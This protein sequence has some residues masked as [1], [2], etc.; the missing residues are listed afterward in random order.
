MRKNIT[1]KRVIMSLLL[2]GITTSAAAAD[3][4][5]IEKGK[6]LYLSNKKGNCIACH[7]INDPDATLPG[8]QG[9]PMVVMKARYPD[10]KQL[11]A[12]IWDPTI[13]NPN[14]IMPPFGKHWILSEDEI[15]AIVAYIYEF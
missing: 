6:K 13:R 3:S 1:I 11:R 7:S 15:D 9:P 14:T 12:Q 2:V 4:S 5:L 10:I 8:L